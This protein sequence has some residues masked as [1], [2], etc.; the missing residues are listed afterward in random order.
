MAKKNPVPLEST[1]L[2]HSSAGHNPPNYLFRP[3]RTRLLKELVK[4]TGK[5]PKLLSIVAPIGYGKTVLMSE[6]H[7]HLLGEGEHC[8]WIGLDERHASVDRVLHSLRVARVGPEA[9]IDPTQALLQGDESIER[10]IDELIESIAQLPAPSTLF[11]DNLN[12][13]VDESLG[14]FLDA[15]VF[16]TPS[17]VRF[18]WSSTTEL[19]INIGRAKLEGLVRQIGYSEL[20]LNARETR[21]LLGDDLDGRIGDAGIEAIQ[22]QTEGWPAAIRMAQIVLA[23][24]DQPLAALETF[25]GSDEDVAALLKRQVLSRFTPGLRD[26]L[27]CLAQLRTFGASLCQYVTGREDAE[28][29]LD[30][31]LRRN[32]FMIPL[33]RNRKRY[34]LHGLFR[35]YLLGEARRLLGAKQRRDVLLRA[36][37][38]S[39]REGEWH[40]AIEYALVAGD[41]GNVSRLLDQTANI[42]VRE[43]GDIPQYI[44]WVERLQTEGERIG[45]ETH[46]WYVWAL[47]FQRRY[48]YGLQQHERLA[49]RLLNHARGDV[50]PDDLPLRIDHLRMCIDLFTDRLAATYERAD[51]WLGS[52]RSHDPYSSGSVGC[53][54]SICLG[55]TFN[56]TQARQAMR[57]AQPILLE[58]GGAYTVGWISLIHGTLSVYEGDYA[59]AYRELLAGLSRARTTLGDDAVLCGTM[60]SVAAKCAV[61]MGL[62][63]EARNLLIS[64]LRTA[65]NNVLVDTVACGFDAAVK[66]WNGGPDELVSIARLREVARGYPP[67]LSLMLSC[68]LIQRLLCLGKLD[69]A[70]AEAAHIGLDICQADVGDHYVEEMSIPRFRDLHAATT[71]ELL[72]ATRRFKQADALIAKEAILAKDD[73]RVARLV[74][75]GLA[76]MAIAMHMN[77]P[78]AATKELAL[79]VGR[80]A[81][82]RIVR[83]FHDRAAVVANLV[84]DTKPGAWSFALAEEREFFAE[85]CRS[86]PTTSNL[87][88]DWS[89]LWGADKSPAVAPTKRE[90]ELLS[91][92]DM[93][94]S[95]QQIAEYSNVSITT[96]KWHL[97]NLY[98]KFDVSNRAAALARARA[99]G[100]LAK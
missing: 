18:V 25:S 63:D 83:P 44:V 77:N 43:H 52:K 31:L 59:H 85:L 16:R 1:P 41:F 7:A 88:Q 6:L 50:P 37:E 51:R 29:H 75:L 86:L 23:E 92:M 24:S 62:K 66:L 78:L 13:C 61:E 46:F 74:D 84:N 90:A 82:R 67:R 30:F 54:K 70:M 49:A 94:L 35:E 68:Y 56:F 4:A 17:S 20:S 57:I 95:N 2:E 42:F 8:Y 5:R 39:E 93:G 96:I 100:L 33:D 48:E 79:A 89:A 21:E 9:G 99:L 32:V 76:K 91:L 40:D 53:I 65:P 34:R 38:W 87:Y 19:A 98:R 47:I 26:F 10:R 15:L 73:G 11:I 97:K 36:A 12:S 71:I 3:V 69:D 64:G 81:R 55:S 72:I 14:A 22:R 28:T 80:A 60:A 58:I 45:W 27:L